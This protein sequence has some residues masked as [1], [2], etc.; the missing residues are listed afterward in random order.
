MDETAIGLHASN[1]ERDVLHSTNTLFLCNNPAE[2]VFDFPMRN[3]DTREWW[4]KKY[5]LISILQKMRII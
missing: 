5:I 1:A 3:K 2:N 4:R